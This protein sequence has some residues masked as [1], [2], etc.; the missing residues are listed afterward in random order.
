MN[1]GIACYTISLLHI[2]NVPNAMITS[3]SAK[4]LMLQTVDAC[5]EKTDESGEFMDLRRRKA[6]QRKV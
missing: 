5:P 6:A 3:I 2:L 4:R 1:K